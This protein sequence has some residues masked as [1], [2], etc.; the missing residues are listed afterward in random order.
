MVSGRNSFVN[1]NVVKTQF[2]LFDR[3]Y[4]S[5]AIVVKMNGFF[6]EEKLFFILYFILL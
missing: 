4:N 6:L 2:V 1:F 5:D 3:C